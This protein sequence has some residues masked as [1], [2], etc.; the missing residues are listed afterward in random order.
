[1]AITTC[2]FDAYGTLSTSPPPRARRQQEPGR[3]LWRSAGRV[4]PRTGASSSWNTPGCAPSRASTRHFWQRDR[5]RARLG[6]GAPRPR[7]GCGAARAPAGA[8]LG[9]RGL[10][11]GA[12]NARRAEGA[13][14]DTAPSSPTARP[15]CWT[16]PSTAPG[17]ATCL[18]AV[19]SV[20][21]GRRLQA[22]RAGLRP[23][24]QALRLRAATRC[25]SSR[26]TA[27]TRRGRRATASPRPGS[28]A[29]AHPV[30]RLPRRPTHVLTDLSPIPELAS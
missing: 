21:D 26:P 10:S 15:T 4:W 9:T 23:G 27:G 11:R 18:D 17:S 19:L 29:R 8:L 2:I 7:R 30:D 1:M 28:T 14:P 25:S 5:R 12:G 13:G 22:R 3:E 24:R 20:E 6:A 16:A